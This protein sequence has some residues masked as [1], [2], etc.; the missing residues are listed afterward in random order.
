MDLN[1][2]RSLT[3]LLMFV[4]FNALIVFVILRGKDAY[5]EAANLPFDEADD[6]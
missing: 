4:A 3:T 5:K 1:D 6:K 2:F